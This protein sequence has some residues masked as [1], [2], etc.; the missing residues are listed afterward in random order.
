MTIC[1]DSY[2]PD[3]TLEQLQWIATIKQKFKF[4][5]DTSTLSFWMVKV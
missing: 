3:T 4:Q 5:V 1:G 2:W